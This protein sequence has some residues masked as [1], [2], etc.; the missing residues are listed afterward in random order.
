MG[1]KDIQGISPNA[2]ELLVQYDW[3]GNVRQ[4]QSA[5]RHS[6]INTTG[7]VIGVDNLPSFLTGTT[8]VR[9]SQVPVADSIP[10]AVESE[11]PSDQLE[12]LEESK[13]A[14]Q[15][16]SLW[17]SNVDDFQLFKFIDE[18][19]AAGS[20]NIYAEALEQME[21]RLFAKVLDVA[22]GNQ[23]KTAEV[24]GITRGTVRDRLA[25]FGILLERSVSVGK[26]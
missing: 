22:N 20:T 15:S 14:E 5:I 13:F 6:M 16:K 26:Q 11:T 9:S 24:L 7:T 18:R 2:Y 3:P 1:K 23:S 10:N 8:L 25:A 17:P 19:L 21:R 4:L 12:D